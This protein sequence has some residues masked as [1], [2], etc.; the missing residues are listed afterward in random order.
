EELG[1]SWLN[2]NGQTRQLRSLLEA[3]PIRLE[4]VTGTFIFTERG[5]EIRNLTGRVE[6]N[7]FRISGQ[8]DGYSPDAP[9]RVRI[10]SLQSENIYI[11]SAPRY[12]RSLP[13]EVRELYDHLRPQ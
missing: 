8:I 9:A 5:V 12:V 10:S 2:L 6:T 11:P 13:R 3:E 1:P 4:Q 7:A